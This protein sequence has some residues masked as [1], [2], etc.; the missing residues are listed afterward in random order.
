MRRI[1]LETFC[2]WIRLRRGCRGTKCQFRNNTCDFPGKLASHPPEKSQ[3][4][5]PV[6]KVGLTF[7]PPLLRSDWRRFLDRACAILT[8]LADAPQSTRKQGLGGR[9][10]FG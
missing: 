8:A 9:L 1:S 4:R 6:A 5:P 3:N 7:M 2:A 10:R